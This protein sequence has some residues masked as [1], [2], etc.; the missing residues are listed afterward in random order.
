[1]GDLNGD[2]KINMLNAIRRNSY[3]Y[4]LDEN[5]NWQQQGNLGN[6]TYRL[7]ALTLDY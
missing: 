4:G 5:Y 1:M 6:Q 3:V 2:G 7:I